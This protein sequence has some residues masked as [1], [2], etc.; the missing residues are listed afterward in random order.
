LYFIALA[1]VEAALAFF[2]TVALK[3]AV[4]ALTDAEAAKVMTNEDMMSVAALFGAV[5]AG[6]ADIHIGGVSLR[7]FMATAFALTAAYRGGA[8]IGSAAGL[9]LALVLYMLGFDREG[10]IAAYGA[11]GLCAG[12]LK[13][14]GRGFTVLAFAVSFL[15]IGY[16][17][18]RS[19]IKGETLFSLGAGAVLFLL[20]PGRLYFNVNPALSHAAN[21]ADDYIER[22]K[23]VTAARL[24]AF[25]NAFANMSR[26]FGG[27]SERKG[28]L[29]K[30]DIS[31]L[32]D[33]IAAQRCYDCV[34]RRYCWEER[35]YETFQSM[36]GLVGL[37]EKKGVIDAKDAPDTFS[38][39]CVKVE[40]IMRT[41]SGL[42]GLGK[43]DMAWNN[44][45]MESREL[46]SQQLA[47]VSEIMKS[48][49]RELDLHINFKRDLEKAVKEEMD[50]A[51]I[52]FESVVVIENADGQYEVTLIHEPSYGKKLCQREIAP[53]VSRALGREMRAIADCSRKNGFCS[54]QFIEERKFRVTRGVARLAKTPHEF[55]GDSYSFM[56]LKNGRYV[57]ALSDGMGTGERAKEESEAA[58]GL[59]ED[60]IESGF[61]KE[62]AVKIINSALV[63]KSDRDSFSTLD[64]CSIDTSTGEAE[65]IKIGAAATFLLREGGV[66]AVKSTSLPLGIL[67]D[68]DV[69]ISRRALK[70]DDL[71]VMATDGVTEAS[72]EYVDK[73]EWI[74]RLLPKI[75]AANPQEIADIILSEAEKKSGKRVKDDMT[76]LVAKIRKKR[77]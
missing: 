24:A 74:I 28:G 69:E 22:V 54:L 51:K 65:F 42:Y 60:F 31:K 14:K 47:G 58:I 68:A 36:F 18:D 6:A 49:S 21:S 61:D 72:D 19:F 5:M 71:I 26:T 55:S 44:R 32:I 66:S 67:D 4:T 10:A 23:D 41:A 57:M 77:L 76:V 13:E 39:V 48:L 16:Y 12:M 11:A 29:T 45:V 2:L 20:M 38:S 3:R 30:N 46:V 50:V 73:G 62:M 64:I 37:C 15:S 8:A 17:M 40:E 33:D 70:H 43:V 1:V 7:M 35:F 53:I 56:E 75:N 63:L 34:K 9:S 27:L 59:L 25:A 52:S